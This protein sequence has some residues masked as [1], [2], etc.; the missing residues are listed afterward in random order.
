MQLYIYVSPKAHIIFDFYVNP[1]YLIKL[2][3]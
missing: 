3:N 2:L 1:F